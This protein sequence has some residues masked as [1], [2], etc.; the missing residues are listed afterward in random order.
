[1]TSPFSCDKTKTPKTLENSGV[2]SHAVAKTD[3]FREEVQG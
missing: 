2:L 1:M 3:L